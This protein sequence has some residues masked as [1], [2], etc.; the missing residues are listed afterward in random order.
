MISELIG[1]LGMKTGG[2]SSID[3]RLGTAQVHTPNGVWHQYGKLGWW[4]GYG[5]NM[6]DFSNWPRLMSL[7]TIVSLF[8]VD[9]MPHVELS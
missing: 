8:N 7:Y 6:S 4:G 2:S 5:V 9:H 3:Q 1:S